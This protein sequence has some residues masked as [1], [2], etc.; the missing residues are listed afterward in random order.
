MSWWIDEDRF[1]AYVQA[2]TRWCRAALARCVRTPR[3]A[4]WIAGRAAAVAAT[5]GD[6]AWTW[7]CSACG[8]WHCGWA[9]P[10]AALVVAGTASRWPRGAGQLS[11]E[12]MLGE[13]L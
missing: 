8:T 10:P 1:A 11:V 2:R 5:G 12:A 7:Q 13:P 4:R 9:P 3:G 6:S